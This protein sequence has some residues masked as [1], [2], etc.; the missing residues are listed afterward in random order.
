MADTGEMYLS[1]IDHYH[2]HHGPGHN[3]Q[4]TREG[5]LNNFNLVDGLFATSSE[6]IS[7]KNT[8]STILKDNQL[9][10]EIERTKEV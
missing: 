2:P 6:G 7:I 9:I 8:K 5:D 3:P 4:F 1:E 10:P